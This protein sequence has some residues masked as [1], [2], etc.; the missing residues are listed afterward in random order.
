MTVTSTVLVVEDEWLIRSLIH[1]ILETEGFV[2][3]TAETGDEAW[4][5]LCETSGG[6][7]LILSDIHF[8]GGMNGV[9]L[10][11]R[12]HGSWPGMPVIL[13]SGG[14]GQQT[15]DSGYTP[16]FIKKPWHS[17]DIGR[18]CRRALALATT[19]RQE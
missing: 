18:I 5:W 1:E 11:N 17:Q 12:V 14:W 4:D 16:I 7:D 13:S 2:V 19:V 9:E 15:L 8:P 10:A 6:A 3:I